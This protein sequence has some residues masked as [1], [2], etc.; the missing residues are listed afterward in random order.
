MQTELFLA[1]SSSILGI[2]VSEMLA[3]SLLIKNAVV[4]FDDE[5]FVSLY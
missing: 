1:A 4:L 2:K 5:M 3:H